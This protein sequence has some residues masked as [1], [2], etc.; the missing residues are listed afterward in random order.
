MTATKE[1]AAKV[2]TVKV[3]RVRSTSEQ[4]SVYTASPEDGPLLD[5]FITVKQFC[6]P[7]RSQQRWCVAGKEIDDPRWGKQFVAQFAT[8]ATPRTEGE[9]SDFIASGLVDGWDMWKLFELRKAAPKGVLAR[10]LA[11]PEFLNDV[12][13]VTPE[14]IASLRGMWQR[15][16]GLAPIYAQLE[17]WG[18][19]GRQADA[20]VKYYGFEAVERLREN[21]YAKILEINGYGWKTAESIALANDILAK[22]PR[23][24]EAGLEVAVHEATWQAGCTWLYEGQ[25]V[26][27]A[28]DLLGV[29][30]AVVEAELA[31]AVAGGHLV[32]D[33]ERIY[34]EHLYRAEQTIAAQIAQ[35]VSRHGNDYR[36]I[37][38]RIDPIDTCSP[39]QTQA[40]LMALAE[41][42]CMLTGGPGTGKTTALKSLIQSARGCGL[43]VTCMAPT[44]KA[45]ARMAE[46]TGYPAT[47]IHSR[48]KIVPGGEGSLDELEP[49]AGLVIVD[50]V[51]ML[52]TGLAA[53]MLSRIGPAAQILLVGD[54]DQLPS[55]GPGAVLRDLIQADVLPRVRL[56]HVY[57]NEAGI[58]VNAARMRAGEDI[59]SLPDCEIVPAESPEGALRRVLDLVRARQSNGTDDGGI[60]VLTPTNDGPSGRL[61]LNTALQ[62]LLSPSPQGSGI[63]QYAGTSTDPDGSIRKRSE[64]LRCG[65]RVMVTKNSSQLGVFNGQ[66]G[67]VVDVMV[68]RSLDVE[69]DGEVINFAGTNKHMLTLAYAITGHKSQG[70]EAP[71]VI[72]PIF[73]SHVL[74]REWLY[75]VIT[76][77]RE[78]CTLIGDVG[79]IQACIKVR[80]AQ[81]RRTGLAEALAET[82]GAV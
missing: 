53:A 41:P 65:D 78:S 72:A 57:R 68:P 44:G 42:I 5:L 36:H 24:V 10:Y 11:E 73:R 15:G 25:A 13:G 1:V 82:V 16:S 79:A 62:A 21:P 33:G 63:V 59:L 64:E 61:A 51:S 47:T 7:V 48:L 29:P 23:R 35:R 18:C 6:G 38:P 27:A 76:R 52:D 34:P 28:R 66:I 3:Q 67:T 19:N 71:I 12:D 39:L 37:A 32:R 43:A 14:M 77:A 26:Q 40:V 30:A 60:L 8:L 80:R 4:F 81:E 17:D 45:A 50:E 74:S 46:A 20:L 75:T 9:F 54:P 49:V 22:D 55:V 69:I 70:S 31:G 2:L 58:A 56:D